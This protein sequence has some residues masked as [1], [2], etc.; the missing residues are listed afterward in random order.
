M[1]KHGDALKL[2]KEIPDNSVDL[3]LTDPPYDA[4][5]HIRTVRLTGMQ[6]K[7]LTEHFYRILKRTGNVIVFTGITDKFKWFNELSNKFIFKRHCL[8]DVFVSIELCEILIKMHKENLIKIVEV[9]NDKV[10]D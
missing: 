6:R 9:K 3:I 2:I 7:I 1:I 8:V 10:E 4:T 5:N